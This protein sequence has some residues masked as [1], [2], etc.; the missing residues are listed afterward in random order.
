MTARMREGAQES[1]TQNVGIGQQ[2]RTVGTGQPVQ[3]R[4]D[5]TVKT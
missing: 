4:E 3:E 2:K 5:S 1:W